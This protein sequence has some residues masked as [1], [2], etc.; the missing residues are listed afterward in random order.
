MSI[1]FEFEFDNDEIRNALSRVAAL[2]QNA[3]IMRKIAGV[4][5][6]EA[7]FAFDNE[8][9]PEGVRWQAL[10]PAYKKRR[11]EQGYTGKILQK[12]G[13][14]VRS[15]AIDY[16]DNLAVVGVSE[17]YGQYHQF[18]TQDMP[19]RPFLGLREAGIE[20]IREILKRELS[21]IASG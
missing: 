17:P 13:D 1:T 7:E 15:L 12:R 10:A 11:D 18:G 19:A 4:L 2:K 8:S 9:S 5:K 16:A 3:H 20:E 14:L 6:Q 21:K